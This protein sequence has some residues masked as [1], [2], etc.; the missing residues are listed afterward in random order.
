M[1]QEKSWSA[2][3]LLRLMVLLVAAGICAGT[4][5]GCGGRGP[6]SPNPP[7]PIDPQR[8]QWEREFAHLLT[9]EMQLPTWREYVIGPGDTI[10]ITM[11]G[12]PDIFGFAQSGNLDSGTGE[13]SQRGPQNILGTLTVQITENPSIILPYVGE[14]QVHGRTASQ[15]QE[16]LRE[17]YAK[18]IRD[19]QPIV[20]I[21]E[22]YQNQVAVLGAVVS[23]GRYP[24][25]VGDTLLDLIFKANGA[26]VGRGNPPARILKIFREKVSM[27]ERSQL[28]PEELLDRLREGDILKP[29][30][31]IL[32]PLD[33]FLIGGDLSYNIPLQAND[34]VYL[35]PAGTIN[36]HGLVNRPRVVFLGPSL[37]TVVQVLTET[38]GLKFAAQST[39][40]VVRTNP[41]GSETSFYMNARRM[42]KRRDADFV[43]RENDQV[44]VYR[45][46][47]RSVV[48]YVESIFKSG[49]SAAGSATY[50]P[51]FDT[52]NNNSNN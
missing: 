18:V 45:N 12:R 20:L 50:G 34:I 32:V 46:P 2:I 28:P 25:D 17:I 23:P 40:E 27:V 33:E 47:W 16:D 52:N 31:E 26:N 36:V 44:F 4:M 14:V 41:D 10:S 3:W 6:K 24:L 21:E 8:A 51:A 13:G 38:G 22:F 35:Q 48:A 37:R 1:Q 19:P 30:E 11:V 39:I 29:R 9:A 43:L 49:L 42:V 15:L 5:A 7:P